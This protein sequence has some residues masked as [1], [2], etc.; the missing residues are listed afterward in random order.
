MSS[1]YNVA[2]SVPH[3]QKK[4]NFEETVNSIVQWQEEAP[5]L[6]QAVQPRWM[7]QQWYTALVK[8]TKWQTG[9]TSGSI[10]KASADLGWESRSQICSARK[11]GVAVFGFQV[12]LSGETMPLDG[13]CYPETIWIKHGDS[14]GRYLGLYILPLSTFIG[15]FTKLLYFFFFVFIGWAVEMGT[16]A[17]A[18][19]FV[20]GG[21]KWVNICKAL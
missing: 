6:N 18:A 14:K 9:M 7:C 8:V 15:T 10:W 20:A 19:S 13:E 3:P 1:G 11:V 17:I 5:L 2:L 12:V 16:I 21:I 4:E